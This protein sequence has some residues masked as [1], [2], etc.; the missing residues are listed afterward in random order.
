[1]SYR[2]TTSKPLI[3]IVL[4]DL[5]VTNPD[6]ALLNLARSAS[7]YISIDAR[8]IE[9]R[10]LAVEKQEGSGIGNGV[11]LPHLRLPG[12][13]RSVALFARN[14]HL[15]DFASVDDTP[16]DLVCLLVSPAETPAD[17]LRRLSRLTRI[18]REDTMLNRLRTADNRDVLEAILTSDIHS[19]LHAA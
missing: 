6:Q 18:F 12:A 5:A 16:V 3:D 10:L 14:R 15:L 17:H 2:A 13:D 7:A 1:M 9:Q 19:T 4:S 8:I 11:A